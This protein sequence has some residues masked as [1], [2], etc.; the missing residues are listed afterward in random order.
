MT[1]LAEALVREYCFLGN[2]Q[3]KPVD[4]S[5]FVL[6]IRPS[7]QFGR[8]HFIQARFSGSARPVF[9]SSI[10]E[11]RLPNGIWN[12]EVERKRLEAVSTPSGTVKLVYVN[13]RNQVAQ[14]SL[15]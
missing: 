1:N 12:I 5:P 9:V 13:K 6:Q 15:P 8:Q 7:K 10:Y 11:P 4:G 14:S 3:L 2:S